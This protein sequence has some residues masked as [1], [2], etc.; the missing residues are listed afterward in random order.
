MSERSAGLTQDVFPFFVGVARS[1]T[2]LLRA[3]MD[4]HPEIAIPP[5]SWFVTELAARRG[6]YESR[7][8]FD[9]ERFATDLVAHER[10]ARW[11]IE[12]DDL[13]AAI[14]ESG[15]GDYP[16]AIR[17]VFSQWAT[18]HG[19]QRYGDKTPG[20][21][22]QLALIVALLPEARIVH[23]IRDGR[24]VALSYSDELG[25]SVVNAMRI[26]RAR[27]RDAREAGRSL[28]HSRYR[29]IRYEDLVADPDATLRVVC[30]F[31]GLPFSDR[32]LCHS[33]HAQQMLAGTPDRH[34]HR[35]VELPL[36][37]GLRD[38]RSQMPAHVIRA[39]GLLAGDLLDDL[40]YEPAPTGFSLR[41]Q[42]LVGRLHLERGAKLA[43]A[44]IAEH[45]GP[46]RLRSASAR[47]ERASTAATRSGP[48]WPNALQRSLLRVVFLE[49]DGAVEEWRMV[50]RRLVLDDV[51][52]PETHRL[53]PLVYRRLM[54]LGVEDP[55]LPRLKGLHRH[56]WYQNQLN[57]SRLAPFLTRLEGAGI[58]T[59]VIKGVPLALR[60]Y[61]DL[62]SRPMN[63]VDVLVPTDR[64]VEALRVLE[65][66]GWR[67]HSDGRGPSQKLT[68]RFS[69]MSHH[70]RIV[71][72]PDG[73][74]V[75]LHWNLREQFVLPGHEM[76]SS[77]DFWAAAEPI[78]VAGVPTRTLCASDLLLHS[79]VHGLVSQRDAQ[80]RWAADAMILVGR[81]G[82][83]HWDRL[84]QQA[85]RRRL[86]LIARAALGY[87][88]DNLD[89]AVPADAIER[90]DG[91]LTTRA[92]EH[93]F[94]RAL[95]HDLYGPR[96][97]WLFDLGPDWAWRRAHL[98]T[99]RAVLD[100]P[101]FL[102]DT[103]QMQHTRDVPVE[104]AR[105]LVERLRHRRRRLTPSS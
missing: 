79:I 12:K 105:H 6:T 44:A 46:R 82:A 71:T 21:L 37:V 16:S 18:R 51:W 17:S 23:L 81:P 67:S 89:A 86:V 77:D 78:D 75:D 83:V 59:M 96:L 101:A 36:T 54:G 73:F 7:H 29:E 74:Y 19:K 98:G 68:A 60:Y 13:R 27:V 52:E 95:T 25:V 43:H 97:Q 53:L 76:A 45:A 92:D 58:R 69:L 48:P 63:D 99:V 49:R 100:L 26:W 2:T 62:G 33:E 24:D 50:R 90:L 1:G 93:A 14:C 47:T 66:A 88:V 8:G 65:E 61:G 20:Y 94:E 32:M 104:A 35:H 40:G 85:E 41:S 57:L 42:A 31:I 22:T 64:M 10:F 70:S 91:V 28:G 38:W 3:M 4:A 56:A 87:L 102:R 72:A 15:P 30:G 84:I 11:G 5:E 39:C 55:E 103:W 80:A 34:R 9:V